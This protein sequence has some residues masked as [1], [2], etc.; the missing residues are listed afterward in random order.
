MRSN[1]KPAASAPNQVADLNRKLNAL[2]M[3]LEDKGVLDAGEF[4]DAN[5]NLKIQL[6]DQMPKTAS[7]EKEKS[8]GARGA[9]KPR[10]TDYVGRERRTRINSKRNTEQERR[11]KIKSAVSH[12]SGEANDKISGRSVSGVQLI[13]RRSMDDKA[14]IQFR[15]T[16]TD[17]QGRYVFLNLPLSKD[18]SDTIDYQYQLEVRYRNQ[19]VE[20]N[21]K[22][23]LIPDK[24]TPFNIQLDLPE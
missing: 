1:K 13:L 8:P 23:D 18:G 20:A 3:L 9:K 10:K 17:M 24:T 21:T 2:I 15:S 5:M 11:T 4:E 19:T 6:G 12:I 7:P 16:K 22:I 14:P